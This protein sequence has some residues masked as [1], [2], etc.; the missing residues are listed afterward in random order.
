MEPGRTLA[1]GDTLHTEILGAHHFGFA[2]LLVE[3]GIL[4]GKQSGYYIIPSGIHPDFVA[5]TI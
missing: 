3:Y 4:R 1:V 5:A 2:T